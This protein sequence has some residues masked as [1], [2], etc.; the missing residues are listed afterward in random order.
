MTPVS[1]S[2]WC[3]HLHNAF[4]RE[5]LSQPAAQTEQ[6]R[7]VR[8]WTGTESAM[9]NLI[10]LGRRHKNAQPIGPHPFN[11]PED[12]ELLTMV[13]NHISGINTSSPG[14][15]T[16]STFIKCA[17]KPVPIQHEKLGKC[18]HASSSH[19][20]SLQTAHCKSQHPQ[21]WERSKAHSHP[22]EGA[23]DTDRELQNDCDNWHVV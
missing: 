15:N 17:C 20:C 7:H 8:Q 14:F 4:R 12:D 10:Q 3:N 1:E 19:C 21:V 11:I 22:Q 5:P 9:D 2:S 16:I 13:T 6:H 23:S 18:Q